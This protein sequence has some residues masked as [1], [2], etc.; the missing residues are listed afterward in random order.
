MEQ[1]QAFSYIEEEGRGSDEKT[2]R[3][4]AAKIGVCEVFG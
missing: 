4:G 3:T 1:R 2:A